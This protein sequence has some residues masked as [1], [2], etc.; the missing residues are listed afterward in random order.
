MISCRFRHTAAE[1]RAL[2]A[3]SKGVRPV[4]YTTL[5]AGVTA[6]GTGLGLGLAVLIGRAL[7]LASP[8]P[9]AG[10]PALAVTVGLFFWLA[11][12]FDGTTMG[13][14]PEVPEQTVTLADDGVT[15]ADAHCETR[16]NWTAF[17]GWSEREG[18]LALSLP[19]GRWLLLPLRGFADEADIAE[20]RAMI[21]ARLPAV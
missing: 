2:Q 14:F 18:A 9:I 17:R 13:D 20:A 16:W 4:T 5:V 15:A 7:D 11:H 8:W 19:D 6:I 3:V 12:R 1:S 10:W 21:A